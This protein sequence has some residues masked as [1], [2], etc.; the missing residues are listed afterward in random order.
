MPRTPDWMT[1]G[2][3]LGLE[4][5]AGPV[6]ALVVLT[7]PLAGRVHYLVSPTTT[8]GRAPDNDLQLDDPEVELWHAAIRYVGNGNGSFYVYDLLSLTGVRVNEMPIPLR[9]ALSHN[10]ELV[11]GRTRLRFID[12]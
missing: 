9:R 1:E 5:L 8:I 10:D 3:A 7:G 4:T 6:P 12:P 11:I 2:E